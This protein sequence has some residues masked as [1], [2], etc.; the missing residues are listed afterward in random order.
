MLTPKFPSLFRVSRNR[1]FDYKPIYYSEEKEKREK[2]A[3]ELAAGK[4]GITRN[5]IKFRPSGARS[6]RNSNMRIVLLV[7]LLTALAVYIITY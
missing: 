2:R 7:V 1:S 6:L 3:K 5:T 4:K